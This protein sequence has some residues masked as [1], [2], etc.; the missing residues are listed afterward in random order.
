[1]APW[2]LRSFAFALAR[3]FG[4]LDSR[5]GGYCVV[6]KSV[7]ISRVIRP[8]DVHSLVNDT[9][10]GFHNPCGLPSQGAAQGTPVNVES[11][12][13]AALRRLAVPEVHEYPHTRVVTSRIVYDGIHPKVAPDKKYQGRKRAPEIR[14]IGK[15]LLAPCIRAVPDGFCCNQSSKKAAPLQRGHVA[16]S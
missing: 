8:V 16:F 7:G 1:M 11:V 10:V 9:G 14:L 2:A 13:L 5:E 4:N 15:Y 3:D 12:F 6:E